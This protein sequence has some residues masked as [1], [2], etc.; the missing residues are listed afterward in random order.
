MMELVEFFNMTNLIDIPLQGTKYT[1]SNRRIGNHLI[2]VKLDR[3]LISANWDISQSLSLSSLPRSGFDHNALLLK[4]NLDHNRVP[5]PFHFE[6]MWGLHL[7]FAALVQSWWEEPIIGT[8][9]YYL[10]EKLRRI[11]QKVK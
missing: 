1:W 10:E 4:R 6:A 2:Q 8:P 11:K 5:F 7:D 9:M 3:F